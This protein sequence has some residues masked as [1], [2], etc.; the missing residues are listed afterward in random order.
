MEVLR[1]PQH[2]GADSPSHGAPSTPLL[3]FLV[4]RM[5]LPPPQTGPNPSLPA[6]L[7]KAP[8]PEAEYA[9]E[10]SRL[11]LIGHASE[12]ISLV[13]PTLSFFTFVSKLDNISSVSRSTVK[14]STLVRVVFW[15]GGPALYLVPREEEVDTVITLLKGDLDE[16]LAP[17]SLKLDVEKVELCCP[18]SSKGI[19]LEMFEKAVLELGRSTLSFTDVEGRVRY[20]HH[21]LSLSSNLLSTLLTPPPPPSPSPLPRSLS[22]GA[23]NRLAF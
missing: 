8:G 21:P 10:Q 2:K 17:P 12:T 18:E 7:A 19:K 22:S 23:M 13:H 1:F 11:L 20:I 4:T 16:A 14:G 3:S 15:T 6:H 9:V 5:T